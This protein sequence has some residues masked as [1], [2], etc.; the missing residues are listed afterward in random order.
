M[1]RTLSPALLLTACALTLTACSR[2]EPAAAPLRPVKLMTVGEGAAAFTTELAGDVRARAVE[3]GDHLGIRARGA[4]R[5]QDADLALAGRET[6]D[7]RCSED[8]KNDSRL[9]RRSVAAKAS[10]V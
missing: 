9:P 5:R 7:H 8:W 6:L 1:K 4:Q 2:E 10:R 3:R